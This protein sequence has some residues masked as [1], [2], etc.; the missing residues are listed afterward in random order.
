MTASPPVRRE[1][2]DRPFLIAENDM[3][4][5][6]AQLVE[7]ITSGPRKTIPPNLR[8]WLHNVP[9]A[10]VAERFGEYVSQLAPLT[11]R[12]KEIIILAVASIWDSDFERHFHERL[13]RQAGLDDAQIDALRAGQPVHFDDAAE[14]VTYALARAL[15]RDHAVPQPLYER[16]ID[17][18][19]HAGIADVVGLMGLYSMI[20]WTV[21]CY[22]LPL[23]PQP[24]PAPAP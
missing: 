8:V 15:L 4:P 6:Q 18:L 12:R 20:A 13:A 19:G 16:A 1:H 5:A 22:Q 21:C 24:A 14:D 9:F 10:T 2:P 3:T 7:R 11:P 17:A 23:P